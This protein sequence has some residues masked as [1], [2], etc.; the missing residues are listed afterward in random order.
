M[1]NEKKVVENTQEETT[2]SKVLGK[3]D[4]VFKKAK[5]I[6]SSIT[7]IVIGTLLIY[8]IYVAFIGNYK[9]DKFVDRVSFDDYSSL[10]LSD[11][12]Q[13]FDSDGS[14]DFSVNSTK[15]V[16]IGK[17][18]TATWSGH[19]DIR[20][21]NGTVDTVSVTIQFNIFT[22]DKETTNIELDTCTIDG[23][24]WS[25][26]EDN[27]L[28]AQNIFQVVMSDTPISTDVAIANATS[29][30]GFEMISFAQK[31]YFNETTSNPSIGTSDG[32][33]DMYGDSTVTTSV[34]EKP[35]S[36]G[37]EDERQY[38]YDGMGFLCEFEN[39]SYNLMTITVDTTISDPNNTY[40][41]IM[42]CDSTGMELVNYGNWAERLDTNKYQLNF[43]DGGALIVEMVDE[44]TASVS[45]IGLNGPVQFDGIYNIGY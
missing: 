34:E 16:E 29:F 37:A 41:T 40:I 11:S 35:E 33:Q 18:E 12:L 7:G 28:G 30:L 3:A 21:E 39:G 9:M 43:T 36:N 22:E 5:S 1:D 2:T 38:E 20:H 8:T 32:N 26:N 42:C 27:A 14:W 6:V 15:D 13:R 23:L 24:S 10:S 25:M 44:Y 19:G 45:S 4:S 17:T 31:G